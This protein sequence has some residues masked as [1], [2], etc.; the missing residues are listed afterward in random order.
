MSRPAP[1]SRVR[2]VVVR[3]VVV[4]DLVV[5][6]C[7][8]VVT[9]ALLAG[10]SGAGEASH[11]ATSASRVATS[12][13]SSAVGTSGATGSSGSS[14]PAESVAPSGSP[15]PAVA[16]RD[17][18][19]AVVLRGWDD[20]RARAFADGD[21]GALRRLYVAGSRAGRADVRVLRGYLR[22]GLRVEG[23]RMQVLALDVV[24]E[25]SG[26]LRLR[27]TDR[28][29][30]GVVVGRGGSLALPLDEASTRVVELVRTRSGRWQ[31][32]SVSEVGSSTRRGGEG[33][34]VRE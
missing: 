32:S 16:A 14:G 12:A 22:R 33:S 5:R 23:L 7:V 18:P 9:T 2:P 6:V 25:A 19:A 10:C 8:V 26:R 4:P 21:P 30:G 28:L 31:V 24:E 27:V 34:A 29:S 11:V 15:R 20:A 3:P 1:C 17:I 13:S